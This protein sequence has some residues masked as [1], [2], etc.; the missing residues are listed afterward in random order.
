MRVRDT[1]F[2]HS[3]KVSR[4]CLRRDERA[5]DEGFRASIGSN[6]SRDQIPSP[7]L[8]APSPYGRGGSTESFGLRL[9]LGLRGGERRVKVG[10]ERKEGFVSLVSG[11]M[12]SI[13]LPSWVFHFR[14]HTRPN[15]ATICLNLT[16][17]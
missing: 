17:G 2:S 13:S 5:T 1:S 12:K 8:R 16:P 10:G 11:R 7:A 4:P 9:I 6:D 3:E 15:A 14:P